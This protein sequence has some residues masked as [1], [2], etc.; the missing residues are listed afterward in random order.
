MS[1]HGGSS[2]TSTA[3]ITNG[4]TMQEDRRQQAL[5]RREL[6]L[7]GGVAEEALREELAADDD[8]PAHREDADERQHAGHDVDAPARASRRTGS[9]AR[10]RAGASGTSVPS[11]ICTTMCDTNSRVFT[12][13]SSAPERLV[14]LV[15]AVDQVEH[16]EREVDDERV[17]QVLRD[18]VEARACRSARRRSP[19]ER[20]VE[21]HHERDA[22]DDRREQEDDRH[23]RRRPPRVR[24]DRSEDEAD[25]AVQQERRRDADDR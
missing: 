25:V 20:H 7:V 16:L 24:L 6:H 18:R 11:T 13:K 10:S 23:Q 15:D 8:V 2:R 5:A 14:R 21:Q 12:M 17:E 22:R 1:A 9:A 4:S 3:R 19:R